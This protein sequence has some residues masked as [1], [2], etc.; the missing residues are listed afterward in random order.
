MKGV[1]KLTAGALIIVFLLSSCAGLLPDPNSITTEEDRVSARNKCFVMYTGGAAVGGA[2]VGFL[3]GDWKGAA[4]GAAAGGAIGFAYAWGKCLGLYS[5]LK[6]QAVGTYSEAAAR[7]NYK[8]SQGQVVK[9]QD[10]SVT[11]S[12]VPAGGAVKL[13]GSYYVLTPDKTTEMKVTE[14]RIVKYYDP[15]KKQWVELGQV[16]QQITAAPGNRKADGNF[17]IPKDVPEGKYK[18]VFKVSTGGQED[19]IE[20]DLN[21]QKGRALGDTNYAALF[22]DYLYR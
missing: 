3:I 5:T 22:T 14:T 12:V 4:V 1:C 8:P 17:D 21:V 18:I 7:A 11:P 6:S 2:L 13:G 15:E 10:F 9:I 19:M 20:K 16:E